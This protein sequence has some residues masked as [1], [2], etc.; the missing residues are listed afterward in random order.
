MTKRKSISFSSVI[1]F[2]EILW[3]TQS[4]KHAGEEI[5]VKRLKLIKMIN[6]FAERSSLM[7]DDRNFSYLAHDLLFE[8]HVNNSHCDDAR[9]KLARSWYR[10]EL[11]R[12]DYRADSKNNSEHSESPE[13]RSERVKSLG[14]VLENC[15]RAFGACSE[16]IFECTHGIYVS[17]QR[18]Q[19]TIVRLRLVQLLRGC[20]TYIL[21][22]NKLVCNFCRNIG[23]ERW[24]WLH[25]F[26]CK[27]RDVLRVTACYRTM[28]FLSSQYILRQLCFNQF[29]TAH[30]RISNHANETSVSEFVAI[31]KPS[32]N[33]YMRR[34]LGTWAKNKNKNKTCQSHGGIE[35]WIC[36]NCSIWPWTY[37]RK[38]WCSVCR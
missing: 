17:G 7:A 20:H 1:E 26:A 25:W 33:N 34:T 4:M 38:R 27:Y 35:H 16:V 22:N 37:K 3:A 12:L 29:L 19:I 32:V 6:W 11:H 23:W 9:M 14:L 21:Y 15:F 31:G 5:T 10:Y 2:Y 18:Y 13:S 36:P 28:C 30:H 24:R 8:I